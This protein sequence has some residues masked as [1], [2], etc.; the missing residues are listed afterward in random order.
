MTLDMT[1]PAR[2]DREV[3]WR[4]YLTPANVIETICVQ[5]FDYHHYDPSRFVDLAAFP[6]EEEAQAAPLSASDVIEA[7]A[8]ASADAVTADQAVRLLVAIGSQHWP[9]APTSYELLYPQGFVAQLRRTAAEED[10]R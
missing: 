7:A 10:S 9:A 8:G 2:W 5:D 1:G 4:R 3:H 6:T